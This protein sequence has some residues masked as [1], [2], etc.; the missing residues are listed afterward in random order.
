ML[1][2]VAD[3][4]TRVLDPQA[5]TYHLPQATFIH[6]PRVTES[7]GQLRARGMAALNRGDMGG[8]AR[9]W[10][11]GKQGAL[12]LPAEAMATALCKS[13]GASPAIGARLQTHSKTVND[14]LDAM[15]TLI[16]EQLIGAV[17]LNHDPDTRFKQT[18]E[19]ID[20]VYRLA[21]E[22]HAR[23]ADQL[24]ARA[25][26]VRRFVFATASAIA[27][28]SMLSALMALAASR[29]TAT[30][31]RQAIEAAEAM[32]NADLTRCLDSRAYEEIGRMARALDK[33][34]ERLSHTLMQVVN[35]SDAVATAGAQLTHGATELG[36]RTEMQAAACRRP[37]P[38]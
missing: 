38:A 7:L 28:A 29:A 13:C 36:G 26:G 2:D 31:A 34:T 20:A 18:T 25:G 6:L 8:V 11:R 14:G 17:A 3:A 35:S 15:A 12:R 4:S 21:D 33:T 24:H 16:D 30:P 9:A 19:A 23:V 10:M 37:P 32:A 1:V 22:A 27:A 5:E